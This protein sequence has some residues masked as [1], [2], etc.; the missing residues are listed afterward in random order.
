MSDTLI[1]WGIG[2]LLT[3]AAVIPTIRRLKAK[4]LASEE[5]DREAH[6]YGLKQPAS[7]HPV[8]DEERCIGIGNCVTACPEG[9]IIGIRNGRGFVA[10][11]ALC[12]GHGACER[13][14]PVQAIRLVFGTAERGVDLPRLTEHYESNVPGLFVVGELGG[15]GLIRNAFE[16]G[17]QCVQ[18]IAKRLGR[19]S[20][21]DVL[22]LVIVGCGPG[23]LAASLYAKHHGLRFVT[24]EREDVGGTVRHYPRKKIVMTTPV[25]IPGGRKIGAREMLKEDL[26]DTWKQVVADAG[27]EIRTGIT[28]QSVDRQADG[29]FHI[30]A[31]GE[32]FRARFVIL[33]IGRRGVPRKLGV[34]G[35]ERSKVAYS[36]REPAAYQ[37]DRVLVVGGG[38]SAVEAALT[39]AYDADADVHVSYRRDAFHRVRP[40]NRERV[41][42]AIQ[43]GRVDVLFDTRVAAIEAEEVALTGTGG[44]RLSLPNDQVF[45][46]AGGELPTP[47]L[48]RCGVEVDTKFGES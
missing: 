26:V 36:L 19:K 12:V 33:A 7:L 14:C 1:V 5:A 8:V 42:E 9:Q 11:P 41:D 17:R 34:P 28:V 31:D 21:S 10:K 20:R 13:A 6:T 45:I 22:D 3:L 35:E 46:F 16:Q 47:F 38:D 48:E 25:K 39:L 27:L 29:T 24:L 2:G 40:K 4:E 44:S 23:G 32:V 18:G 37:G 30:Q 43:S 15:M